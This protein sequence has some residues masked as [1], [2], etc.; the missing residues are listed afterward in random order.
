[1]K[2]IIYNS[3]GKILRLISAP[4]DRLSLQV[5]AGELMLIG[6]ANEFANYID[7]GTVTQRPTQP[8]SL[9]KLTLTADGVDLITI[10]NEPIGATF[11]AVNT[12]SGKV[13]TGLIDGTDS[14]STTIVGAY[15]ITIVLWPYLDFEVTVNAI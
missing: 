10:T 5:Q 13:V 7:Q 3:V 8:T 15:K 12:V 9:S 11:T 1:M 14:F 2:A 6:E 4:E